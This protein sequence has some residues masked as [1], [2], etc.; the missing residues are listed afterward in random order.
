[1]TE[2]SQPRTE[3]LDKETIHMKSHKLLTIAVAAVMATSGLGTMI[4]SQS[5]HASGPSQEVVTTPTYPG[6]EVLV[7]R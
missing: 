6:M 2:T 1:M 5:A 4:P 7:P 3:S